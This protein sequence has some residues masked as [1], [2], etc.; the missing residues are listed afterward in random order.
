[1]R[2]R[3]RASTA[4][5][6]SVTAGGRPQTPQYD[7]AALEKGMEAHVNEVGSS[8]AFE[9]KSYWT[10]PTT[11]AV[12]GHDALTV[13]P[14]MAV[15][16][17]SVPYCMI[18]F[19][20]VRRIMI[21]LAMSKPA[22]IAAVPANHKIVTAIQYGDIMADRFMTLCAHFRRLATN[23]KKRQ[24]CL[25]Q[26][27]PAD[28]AKLMEVIGQIRVDLPGPAPTSEPSVVSQVAAAEGSAPQ[29]APKR[30][31]IPRLAS[32]FF[33]ASPKKAKKD[34]DE[35]AAASPIPM[36]PKTGS[37][38]RFQGVFSPG[39]SRLLEEAELCSP[40]PPKKAVVKALVQEVRVAAKEEK[41]TAKAQSKAQGKVKAKA[42]PKAKAKGKTKAAAK[43]KAQV[44]A[45]AVPQMRQ[46]GEWTL[47][48]KVRSERDKQAG[49]LY[50]EYIAPSGI[51]HR[52]RAQALTR[53]FV[54]N[55]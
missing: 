50:Y 22:L 13:C 40:V 44:R 34:E 53:G 54:E 2:T 20:D 25:K 11:Y 48:Q 1:M 26:L 29:A 38:P 32:E 31:G 17:A 28:A 9:L 14:I 51:R 39:T 3:P 12:R 18:W 55:P 7:S 43:A 42:G 52:S 5:R 8:K 35:G 37:A 41:A 33:S 27:A 46:V 36:T 49:E 16:V 23:D 30:R 45:G 47:V 24:E 10:V 4:A 21:N 15:V 6:T 19:S